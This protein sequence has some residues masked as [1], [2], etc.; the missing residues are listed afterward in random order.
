M[1]LLDLPLVPSPDEARRKLLA[2]LA[3][4]EY[5]GAQTLLN[6]WIDRLLGELLDRTPGQLPTGPAVAIGLGIV[7]A[8][9]WLVGR[10]R[11]NQD[12]KRRE[13]SALVDPKLTPADYR[14]LA[15]QALAASRFDEATVAA[16]RAIVSDLDRRAVL[17]DRPGRTAHEAATAM[18]SA[19]PAQAEAFR[20][21][22]DWFDLAAYGIDQG[23]RQRTT[24]AQARTL[25]DLGTELAGTRPVFRDASDEV[26]APTPTG[27][28]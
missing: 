20:L 10:T 28:A 9:I 14:G 17:G 27:S 26:R 3:R 15:E 7:L 12:Q 1:L 11:F 5:G 19:F 25:L 13:R 21:G 24:A 18:S 2:E 16:F 6:Q 23:G 8:L 22:A 4:P